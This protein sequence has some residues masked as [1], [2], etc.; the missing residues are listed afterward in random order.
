MPMTVRWGDSDLTI[1]HYTVSGIWSWEEFFNT[2]EYGRKMR[3]QR[4]SEPVRVIVD[5]SETHH[6]PTGAV[7]HFGNLFRRGAPSTDQVERV[8][9][10]K[11]GRFLAAIADILLK[12]NP[13]AVSKVTFVDSIAEAYALLGQSQES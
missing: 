13:K 6:L 2:I 9:I 1:L 4:G 3:E 10:V 7:S 5:F 12:L 11:P 8:I